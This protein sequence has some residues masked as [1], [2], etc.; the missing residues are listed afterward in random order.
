MHFFKKYFHFKKRG[1]FV[2]EGENYANLIV[3]DAI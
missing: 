1:E 3:F 2:S